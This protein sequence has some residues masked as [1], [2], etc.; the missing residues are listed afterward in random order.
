MK[1]VLIT[2]TVLIALV[3]WSAPVKA[4]IMAAGSDS[5]IELVKQ[6]VAG[7]EAETGVKIAITGGGSSVGAKSCLE[8]KCD[9]AFLSRDLK[10]E[11]VKA[12][13]VAAPYAIDGVAVIVNKN[14]PVENV[15]LEDLQ[16]L[17]TG[18][19]ATWPDGKAVLLFNR[20][21]SSGTRECFEH[22]VMKKKAFSPK[23]QIKHDA[24]LYESIAKIVTSVGYTSACHA[25]EDL[26]VVKVNNVIPNADSLADG[27]YPICRTLNF[28]TKGAAQGDAK[29][30]IEYVL[31]DKGKEIIRKAGYVPHVKKD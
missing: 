6:L 5:T 26:K 18:E 24:V 15:T 20:N 19:T 13:L 12:G 16:K 27:S 7:F 29:A 8:G 23:A 31:G 30:F 25:S 4:E 1:N 2:M 9:L 3:W 17:F 22:V 10:E 14:N 21:E 11:E 28:A